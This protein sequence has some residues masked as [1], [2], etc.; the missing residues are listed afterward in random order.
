MMDG[1]KIIEDDQVPPGSV[2]IMPQN[3]NTI[4]T[5]F[6]LEDNYYHMDTYEKGYHDGIEGDNLNQSLC[7]NEDYILGY[8]D[9][10]ADAERKLEQADDIIMGLPAQLI[11]YEDGRE[12][13]RQ[14]I[15]DQVSSYTFTAHCSW[16]LIAGV[17]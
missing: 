13:I 12:L 2:W 14:K 9:G 3:V 6:K 10:Y 15:Y 17:L 4:N 1:I 11:L 8:D 16:S 7:G 5:T